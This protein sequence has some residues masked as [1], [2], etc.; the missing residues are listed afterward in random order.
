MIKNSFAWSLR[1]AF[2]VARAQPMREAGNKYNDTILSIFESPM[3]GNAR[4]ND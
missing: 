3:I 1:S 2:L 4:K